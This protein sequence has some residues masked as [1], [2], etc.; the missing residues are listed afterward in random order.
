MYRG[1]YSGKQLPDF[2]RNVCANILHGSAD[3]CGYLGSTVHDRYPIFQIMIRLMIVLTSTS[4]CFQLWRVCL[5]RI[6]RPSTSSMPFMA[7]L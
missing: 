5:W 4:K 1:I 7:K 3:F 2:C 6:Y